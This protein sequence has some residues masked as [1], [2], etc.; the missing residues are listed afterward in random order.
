MKLRDIFE[1]RA[2]PS[3]NAK[4]SINKKI[5]ERLDRT[6]TTIAEI[7]NAFIT[8]TSIDK[9]G[10]NPRSKYKTPNGIYCY[11]LSYVYSETGDDKS[12][13]VL[14]FAGDQM[15]ATIFSAKGN[16]VNLNSMTDEDKDN[17][18]NI[19]QQADSVIRQ[20]V[21]RLSTTVEQARVVS[22][23]GIF[24]YIT[25]QLSIHL[26]KNSNNIWNG[27]FRKMGID[28]CVDMGTG[29]IH[30]NEPTQ[31]VFF[32]KGVISN[33]ERVYNKYSQSNVD[34]RV[35]H[36]K[37]AVYA[38]EKMKKFLKH[39]DYDGLVEF[40][41]YS[42]YGVFINR[43][44]P[45]VR[46]TLITIDPLLFDM[47]DEPTIDELLLVS[48]N[49]LVD[50]TKL[51]VKKISPDDFLKLGDLY[52]KKSRLNI[53]LSFFDNSILPE[54]SQVFLKDLRIINFIKQCIELNPLLIFRIKK[55]A[56]IVPSLIE[57]AYKIIIDK[58]I[59]LSDND[60]DLFNVILSKIGKKLD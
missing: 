12:M 23:G 34:D 53:L 22:P 36:G 11:P 35:M 47:I 3:L 25:Y 44:H 31:A 40:L 16:I 2:N 52:A 5:K 39:K 51:N 37:Q 59:D 6:N 29:I 46:G 42:Q 20:L 14:P 32:T 38:T 28:G 8:F 18:L 17:Y 49:G 1:K 57:Y 56:A 60:K 41:R 54:R 21:D 48:N 58:N 50:L 27:L 10:I 15:Y 26:G 19:L 13:E 43:L 9:L 55:T 33:E 7:P 24:W 4:H 45:I 30:P